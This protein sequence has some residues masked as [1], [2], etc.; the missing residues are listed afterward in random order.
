M[1]SRWLHPLRTRGRNHVGDMSAENDLRGRWR[2]QAHREGNAAAR[3]VLRRSPLAQPMFKVSAPMPNSSRP[4]A[5]PT[6][7]RAERCGGG[8]DETH[9]GSP[10][11]HAG[12]AKAIDEDAAY[13]NQ[14]YIWQVVNALSIPICV[15]LKSRCRCRRSELADGIVNVEIAA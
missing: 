8:T 13:E 2:G 4:P 3:K 14:H 11:S 1:T 6:K 5:M 9:C 7:P 12:S 15:S 10:K